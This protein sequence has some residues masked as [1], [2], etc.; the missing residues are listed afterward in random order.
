MKKFMAEFKEFISRGNVIDLAVGVM[1]GGAFNAIVT[2]LCEKVISP[3]INFI[4]GLIAGQSIEEMTSALKVGPVDNPID[5]GAL[6]SAI[7]NFIIM[8]F[9]IFLIVKAFNKLAAL[10]KKEEKEEAP[11][12]KEC[13]FCCSEINIKATRCPCC[14]ADLRV[15]K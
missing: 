13:P 15:K 2:T 5:F 4:I 1:I 8:A 11:T 12:T 14:T 9:I 7:I 6:I 10:R 3:F